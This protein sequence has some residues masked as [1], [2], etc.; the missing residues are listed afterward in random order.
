MSKIRISAQDPIWADINSAQTILGIFA[1]ETECQNEC[2]T[3][4]DVASRLHGQ[5]PYTYIIYP[6]IK[7]DIY[8]SYITKEGTISKEHKLRYEPETKLF[9][10]GHPGSFPTV[11]E[12][13]VAIMGCGANE[14][15]SLQ[16]SA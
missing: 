7:G 9:R 8:L 11:A 4:F 12:L 15:K 3:F 14:A 10:N 13:I 2:L 1:N 5:K 6:D 16:E